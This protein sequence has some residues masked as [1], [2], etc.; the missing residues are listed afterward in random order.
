MK[1]YKL[2]KTEGLPFASVLEWL[3]CSQYDT[4]V[5][6]SAFGMQKYWLSVTVGGDFISSS[7]VSINLNVGDIEFDQWRISPLDGDGCHVDEFQLP[8]KYSEKLLAMGLIEEVPEKHTGEAYSIRVPVCPKCGD[9]TPK[10]ACGVVGGEVKC[11]VYCYIGE[12]GHEGEY[13]NS[14][15]E[16]CLDFGDFGED[17]PSNG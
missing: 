9:K 5:Y 1:K 8:G 4:G 3:K 2:V 16:A 14:L 15:E 6:M 17:E 10:L 7:G 11:K 13:R 12:C